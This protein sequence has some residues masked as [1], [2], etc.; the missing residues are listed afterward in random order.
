MK[1]SSTQTLCSRHKGYVSKEK[2]QFEQL[3]KSKVTS[4][5]SKRIYKIGNIK[6]LKANQRYLYIQNLKPKNNLHLVKNGDTYYQIR[7]PPSMAKPDGK[8][9]YMKKSNGNVVWEQDRRF[10]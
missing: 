10:M 6:R 8:G 1:I 7:I 9:W 3:A 5:V 2:K 4:P